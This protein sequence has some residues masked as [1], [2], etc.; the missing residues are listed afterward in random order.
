MTGTGG[1]APARSAAV[2]PVVAGIDSSTGATKVEL[3][4]P[5]SGML[6]GAA[7]TAHTPVTPPHARHDPEMWW[8]ALCAALD[9]AVARA[10]AAHPV[11]VAAISVAAQQH[12][13]V[14]LDGEGTLLA[15]APLWCDTT[16]A[17][18]AAALIDLLPGGAVGW[19][20]ACGSVPVPS[21]TIT[22]LAQL[23]REHPDRFG[24]LGT[25]L[26]PHDW[27][28]WRLSG[29]RVTDRGDASGTGYWSPDR[30]SW[31]I[32]LLDLVD[33]AT[34]WSAVL[35]EVLA[36]DAAVGATAGEAARRWPGAAVGPGTGD[37]M[38]A[39]LGLGL[40]AGDV[41]ISLGTS[42]TVFAVSEH[43]THDPAGLVAGFADAT[44]RFLP[45][46]C[47]LNATKVL[48]ATARL[49][50][51]DLAGFDALAVAAPVGADGVTL[52]PYFDGERTPDR[53]SSTG[54]VAGLRSDVT[55]EQ[56]ARAAVEGVVCGLLDGMDALGSHVP[57]DGQVWVLG[58]GAHSPAARRAL[59]TLL[60]RE[61]RRSSLDEAVA[62]GACVQAAAVL[63][64][65][66]P[67][68]VRAEW[69]LEGGDVTEPEDAGRDEVA[70]LRVRYRTLRD[71]G[72]GDPIS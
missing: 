68:A 5:G 39:A 34:D 7:Q 69:E 67:A 36:P 63:R 19:A 57:T 11:R 15:D 3:R 44:G 71:S 25:L 48:D 20:E 35:P 45:L 60:G 24:R 42:G 46:V 66:D 43:P 4:D 64:G 18:D 54:V 8:S 49:L 31:A 12:G 28:T 65:S 32:E 38:A 62:T 47:T 58:G 59:A 51:V 2:R 72:A 37:N 41:A 56:L 17:P 53:P 29:R 50:G 1:S 27:L 23:R 52:L 33:D 30:E 22:K 9:T 16:S 61:V 14:A 70:A 6:L 55:R 40:R 10:G 21:F 26:L 13:M